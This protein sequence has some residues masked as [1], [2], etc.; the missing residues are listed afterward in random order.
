MIGLDCLF[1]FGNCSLVPVPNQDHPDIKTC[2]KGQITFDDFINIGVLESASHPSF[3]TL[4]M[5]LS[6]AND[7]SNFLLS[8]F[9][10]V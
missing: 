9:V 5:N 3:V 1:V 2:S 6:F 4:G 8:A 7:Q 10:Y